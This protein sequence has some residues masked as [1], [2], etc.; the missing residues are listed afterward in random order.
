[1]ADAQALA[2]QLT[3]LQQDFAALQAQ[4]QGLQ[5]PP[6][7]QPP[8]PPV[9]NPP[10]VVHPYEG[11]ALDIS[12]KVGF[13]LFQE[14]SSPL[15]ATFS[16]K[17]EELHTFKGELTKRANYC[18]WDTGAHKILTI[19]RIS[20]GQTF[21]LLEEFGYLKRS[22]IDAAR[23]V[24]EAGTD[25]RAKQ[26]A[27][28][29]YNCLFSSIVQNAKE[30]LLTSDE[31]LPEDG[32]TLFFMVI[33]RTY[34]ATFHNAQ[35]A[36]SLLNKLHPKNYNFDLQKFHAAVRLLKKDVQSSP[37]NQASESELIF[38]LLAAY[39]KI[40]QPPEWA[41]FVHYLFND[42]SK[43]REAYT[44]STIMAE[45]ESKVKQLRD[46]KL[47][48]PSGTSD[49][50]QQPVAMRGEFQKNKKKDK[51]KNNDNDSKDSTKTNSNKPPFLKKPGKEGDTKKWNDQTWYYCSGP[52]PS[53]GPGWGT[54]KPEDCHAKKKDK[55]N[56]SGGGTKS[57][58]IKVDKHRL[59]TAM[60][61]IFAANSYDAFDPDSIASSVI[62]ALQE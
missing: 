58:N 31:K 45:A 26:N 55:N 38:Y 49:S 24:R 41:S 1:M 57:D 6:A 62:E 43:N 36:R 37:D 44:L 10:T 4:L 21:N 22:D 27:L 12:A 46:Q 13:S 35:A 5:Q 7:G 47:W 39:Q 50:D 34:V 3:Q 2:Q 53:K 56:S 14:A 59:T 9:P 33:S 42:M 29:M 61:S 28:M 52:H 48:K 15:S 54:H 40:K 25:I 32:P 16:G 18:R 19:T 17:Y 8:A 11:G 23:A 51:Q 60:A 30:E 20:D